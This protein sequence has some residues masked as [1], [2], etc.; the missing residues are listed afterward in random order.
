MIVKPKPYGIDQS[1]GYLF[2]DVKYK[3]DLFIPNNNYDTTTRLE[4]PV[5]TYNEIND[6]IQ[7][8]FKVNSDL[9]EYIYGKGAKHNLLL[10]PD[11]KHK[12]PHIKKK[13]KAQQ[14]AYS[15]HTSKVILQETIIGIAEFFN[16][17]PN[18]YIYFPVRLDQRGR[19]Y[20]APSYFNYQS[21]ELAKSLFLFSNPGVV[22]KSNLKPIDN[23]KKYGA[24]CYGGKVSK[25]S[26]ISKLKWVNN[27]IDN[28][29]N[30]DNGI[31]LNKAADKLLFLSFCMEFNRFWEF[32]NKENLMSFHTYLPIRLDATC[33]GFQHMALLSDEFSLFKELN[34]SGGKEDKTP[35]DFYNFLLHKVINVR[36]M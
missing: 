19:L 9:L 31:L 21:N 7:T 17:Y 13:T 35:N 15:S 29:L 26:D 6:L 23:L 8:P 3:E 20:C 14:S 10:D 1:E 16:K 24:N 18:I 28:I 30:Y 34:L 33:N 36:K 32:Y 5:K 4:N 27:N 22:Y 11:A 2:N 12:Y 25:Y